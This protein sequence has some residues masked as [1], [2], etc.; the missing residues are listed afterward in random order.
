LLESSIN[1][2]IFDAK[3]KD[4]KLDTAPVIISCVIGCIFLTQHCVYAKDAAQE[5]TKIVKYLSNLGPPTLLTALEIYKVRA[6]IKMYIK[7]VQL[8]LHERQIS[9]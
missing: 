9:T 8:H 3:L 4:N 2:T 6:Y 7:N 1:N 5:G